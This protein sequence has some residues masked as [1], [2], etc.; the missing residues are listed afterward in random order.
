[1]NKLYPT[2]QR[3]AEAAE[4]ISSQLE[5]VGTLAERLDKIEA[6]LNRLVE[7]RAKE[8]YT[9]A[10][11]AQ[12]LG[13]AEFTVREWCRLGRVRAGKRKCGRGQSQEWVIAHAELERIKNEGLLP[14]PK[15]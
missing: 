13:R 1:M 8:W 7:Q 6:A 14:L 9:T 12:I 10:E 11:A 4:H 5:V 3:I 15:D 2:L